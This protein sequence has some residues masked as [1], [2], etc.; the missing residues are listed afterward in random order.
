M[1]ATVQMDTRTLERALKEWSAFVREDCTEVVASEAR[2]LFLDGMN[3]TPPFGKGRNKGSTKAAQ[4]QGEAAIER[5]VMNSMRP[6]DPDEVRSA[7]LERAMEGPN[8]VNDTDEYFRKIG[9]GRGQA[10][11]VT[12]QARYHQDDRNKR[13][14]R[15]KGFRGRYLA[16]RS[17]RRALDFY[18]A[19]LKDKSGTF[20]A[21][22]AIAAMEV[23]KHTGEKARIPGWVRKRMPS[24]RRLVV[25]QR[26]NL[27]KG[28]GLRRSNI[29][30]SVTIVGHDMTE[31]AYERAISKRKRALFHKVRLV[32]NNQTHRLNTGRF[33]LR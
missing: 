25:A 13:S 28:G 27:R 1:S 12:F 22:F 14:G 32:V 11:A 19:S 23:A 31:Y 24:A 17:D 20:K 8:P 2:L 16:T 3:L 9:K 15:V 6:L 5:S 30:I 18:I 29:D 7:W 33:T 4:E 26:Y 10:R 21:A